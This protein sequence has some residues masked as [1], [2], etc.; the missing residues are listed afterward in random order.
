MAEELGVAS[1]NGIRV[2]YRI[3]GSGP[4]LVLLHGWPQTGLCWHRIAPDLAATHTVIAP[5]LRGYGR[6]DKPVGGYDKRTM[7]ADIAGLLE[8]LG[9]STAA[10]VGHDRGARVAHRWALDRPDQVTKLAVL[11]VIPTREVW[12]LMNADIARRYFHWLFHLQPDLPELLVGQ[13]ISGYLRYFFEHWTVNRHGL[14]EEA[15]DEYIR[16][17]SVPGALR[18]GFDDYRAA[19]LDAEHDDADA[20]RSLRQPVLALWGSGSFLE[21]LPALDIWRKYADDVQG[22]P[23]P[24]CGHFIAEERPEVLV[25]RLRAFL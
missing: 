6:T 18:A 8:H 3:S 22:G 5:D 16:A 23:I 19:E 11:D 10:V 1:V 20:E 24:D 21:K 25:D 7:A 9:V 15:V 14:T 13:N 4:A 2:H 12:R 17:F